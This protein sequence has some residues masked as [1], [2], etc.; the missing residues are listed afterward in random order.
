M[1]RLQIEL[2]AEMDDGRTLEVVADQRDVAR[3]EVQP[4]GCPMSEW[5]SRINLAYRWLA[6]S[7]LTRHQ[8]LAGPD[9]KQ[10]TWDQFDSLC[11]EVSDPPGDDGDQGD[12]VGGGDADPGQPDP[13]A[14]TSSRSRGVRAKR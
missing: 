11:I 3:W 4:F 9:G 8:L 14:P 12:G 5:S 7:A 6:W 10:L 1:P 2:S 13:S